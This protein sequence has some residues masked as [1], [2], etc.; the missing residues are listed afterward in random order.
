MSSLFEV[1]EASLQDEIL[2]YSD[3]LVK[4]VTSFGNAF[5]LFLSLF[6]N[7]YEKLLIYVASFDSTC[8]VTCLN[9]SLNLFSS[10]GCTPII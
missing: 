3:I 5:E 2:R 6:A 1:T 10:S 4:I 9:D 8:G 7:K